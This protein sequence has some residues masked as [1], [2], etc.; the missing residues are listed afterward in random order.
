[1]GSWNTGGTMF[2]TLK[3]GRASLHHMQYRYSQKKIT[4]LV[5]LFDKS[6]TFR[7]SVVHD[8][9]NDMSY[10]AKLILG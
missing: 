7:I 10:D 8:L 3:W 5:N 4:P 9:T 6:M 1:M 2:Y